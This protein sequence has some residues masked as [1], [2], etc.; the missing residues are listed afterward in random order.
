[1]FT[2]HQAEVADG[3]WP[4]LH[5]GESVFFC[6]GVFAASGSVCSCRR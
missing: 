6:S 3:S 5:L 4:T 1:M 2:M